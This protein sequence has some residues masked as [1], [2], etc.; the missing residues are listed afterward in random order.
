MIKILILSLLYTSFDEIEKF[1]S[2][3]KTLASEI[4]D[5]MLND[6]AVDEQL[7]TLLLKSM[8]IYCFSD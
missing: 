6:M 4:V 8:K 1:G 7:Q 2:D 5:L 3:E